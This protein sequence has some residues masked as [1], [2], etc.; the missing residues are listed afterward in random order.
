MR[1]GN[2]LCENLGKSLVGR[3]SSRPISGVSMGA[4]WQHQGQQ[5]E[6]RGRAVGNEAEEGGRDQ[7][8]WGFVVRIRTILGFIESVKAI[9][10]LRILN[11]GE[12]RD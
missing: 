11:S 3:G 6:Q 4:E 12:T 7:T 8:V 10:K 5:A 1:S 2:E 9:G